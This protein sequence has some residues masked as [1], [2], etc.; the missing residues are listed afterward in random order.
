MNVEDV[1]KKIRELREKLGLS[2]V[3]FATRLDEDQSKISKWERGKQRPN[4]DGAAKLAALAGQSVAEWWG[5]APL[6]ATDINAPMV[7]VIGELRAG[8]WREAVEWPH[9]DQFTVPVPRDPA[10]P[11]LPLQGFIVRGESMNRIYPD[12]TLVFVAATIPNGIKPK[13]GDIVLVQRRNRDG[14]YEATLKELVVSEDG[15]RWLWP[16]SSDPEHQAP[17]QYRSTDAEEVTVTGVVDTAVLFR[18]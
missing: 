4:A 12:G 14:L 17:L 13:S 16:R 7:R 18:R 5:V 9:D 2:Q 10:K 15:A 6:R 1:G 3:E 11:A 8:A